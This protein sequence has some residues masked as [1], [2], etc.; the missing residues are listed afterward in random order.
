[1]NDIDSPSYQSIILHIYKR[2]CIQCLVIL[3]HFTCDRKC[4]IIL[5][6][7]MNIYQPSNISSMQLLYFFTLVI[8]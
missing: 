2:Y 1:M 3:D 5:S 4:R 7:D 6:I 8:C